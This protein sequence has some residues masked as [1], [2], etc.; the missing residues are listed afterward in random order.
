LIN[1]TFPWLRGS[2]RWKLLL[3]VVL[4]ETLMLLMLYVNNAQLFNLIALLGLVLTIFGISVAA[5]WLSRQVK[6]LRQALRVKDAAIE[7]SVNAIVIAGVDGKL[8]Y[9]NRA[10]VEL[11]RLRGAEDAIGRSP[12][13]FWDKPDVAQ[14][15][16]EA[17]QQQG[18][19]QGEL[20]ARR[21]DGS[22]M[23]LEVSVSLVMDGSGKPVCMTGW[24]VDITERQLAQA[25]LRQLNDELE[26]R[27]EQRTAELV[28]AV[29][30]AERA[31]SAKSEFLAR[32]SHELRTP[33]NGILGFAQLLAYDTAHSLDAEQLDYVQEIV[34]AGEHLL[35]LINEVLDLARIESGRVALMTEPLAIAQLVRECVPLVQALA[36]KSNLRMN[37]EL[38]GDYVIRADPLRL[39]QIL[40]NLLSNAVKYNR[41]GGS[42]E[43]SC[44]SVRKG[45]VRLAVNDSG[46]GI[47][48]DALPRLFLPFE[49]LEAVYNGIEG[50]G[51]GLAISKRLTEAMGGIIG[52]ESIAGA[53][54]TFWVE[55]P[56]DAGMDVEP[57]PD[58]ATMQTA[59]PNLRTLL[60]IEDNPSS[61][62]LVQKSIC[63]RLGLVML[64]A[65]TA[66][67]GLE[68]ARARRPDIIL[69]NIS[70]PGMNGFGVLSELQHDNA[71]RDIPVIAII[72]NAMEHDIKKVLNA[73]F[74]DYLTKP[75]DIILLLVLLSK[76]LER[77][78]YL[79]QG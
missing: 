12:T 17:V 50:A 31:N 61:L 51:I 14:G 39:R 35:E 42:I 57:L 5:Y 45:W 25:A 58:L 63:S 41:E 7:S 29:N 30:E 23:E 3:A 68:M 55:F 75:L 26:Q 37:V 53:G 10:F 20:T 1:T 48:A 8:S 64:N 72:A 74:V 19:W 16:I 33:M 40:L 34:H 67:L 9:V 28:S 47:A 71:T 66:E 2:L 24:F 49:R 60:Y 56:L 15:V 70:L 76:L 79:S 22:V 6:K 27:V 54:S 11:W 13:E 73:G 43:I 18:R 32:M 59:P 78:R 44:L 21:D 36:A 62:R 52:V 69:L 77:Q 46:R 38:T 65:H 4:V